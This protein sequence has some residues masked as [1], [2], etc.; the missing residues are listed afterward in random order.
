MARSLFNLMFAVTTI[1][2]SS[3]H[4]LDT[5][6]DCQNALTKQFAE[7]KVEDLYDTDKS[8]A[9]SFFVKELFDRL[10]F[11]DK[12]NLKVPQFKLQ[13]PRVIQQ[14]RDALVRYN[15]KNGFLK[16]QPYRFLTAGDETTSIPKTLEQT[17]NQVIVEAETHLR[18]D[19]VTYFWYLTFLNDAKNLIQNADKDFGPVEHAQR[20]RDY[21]YNTIRDKGVLFW[22]TF[23]AL[24]YF[25]FYGTF[26]NGIVLGG[27]KESENNK[28]DDKT[29][30][31]SWAYLEHDFF[32]HSSRWYARNKEALN[33]IKKFL[34]RVN[35]LISKFD[36]DRQN[37]I[38]TIIGQINHEHFATIYLAGTPYSRERIQQFYL[39]FPSYFYENLIRSERKLQH[40]RDLDY[41]K[42]KERIAAAKLNTLNVLDEAVKTFLS[43]RN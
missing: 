34:D 39:D 28:F 18:N 29:N 22:P 23:A 9:D 37:E 3:A 2:V 4:A 43:D 5:L 21:I 15:N 6:I 31:S 30:A 42:Q 1:F 20:L 41:S 32:Q 24:D 11:E 36:I 27:V 12:L 35:Q 19:D 7:T 40:L 25:D 13:L 26:E 8:V 10:S 38:R 16:D 14:L 17:I 33:K